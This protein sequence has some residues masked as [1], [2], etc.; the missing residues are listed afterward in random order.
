MHILAYSLRLKILIY[1][2]KKVEI[3]LLFTKKVI[4]LSKYLFEFF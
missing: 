4:I 3:T 2:I 1:L